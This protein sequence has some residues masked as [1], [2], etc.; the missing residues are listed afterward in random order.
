MIHAYTSFQVTPSS[1]SSNP[2]RHNGIE[3]TSKMG[4]MSKSR[5]IVLDVRSPSEFKRGAL[6]DSFNVPFS[7]AYK[8]EQTG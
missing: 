4:R 8:L 7:K 5:M 2:S 3:P 6:P 1:V